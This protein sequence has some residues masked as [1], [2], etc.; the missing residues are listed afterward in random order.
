MQIHNELTS[1]EN[2]DMGFSIVTKAR[3]RIELER[4]LEHLQNF[5]DKRT[6]VRIAKRNIIIIDRIEL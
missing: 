5:L 6:S 4:C 3:H 1:N 2:A